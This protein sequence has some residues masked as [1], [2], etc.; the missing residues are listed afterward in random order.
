[1]SRLLR[2][3]AIPVLLLAGSLNTGCS[4]SAGSDP[5]TSTSSATPTSPALSASSGVAPVAATVK[6][7]GPLNVLMLSVDCLRADMPWNGY[8]RPIAPNLTRLAEESTVYTNAYSASSYTAQ[9]VAAIL[10]GR[11]ASTLYRSGV[12]FTSYPKANLFFPEVL[13]EKGIRSMG[14]FSHLYFGRGKGIEQGFDVW[15]LVP[16]ITFN[17]QTDEHVTSDKMLELGLKILRKSREYEGAFLRMGAFRRSA[18]PVHQTQGGAGLRQ[19]DSRQV[20]LR[21]LV[22]R[23]SHR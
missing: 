22:H 10:S 12:F 13:S 5:V 9:S 11:F 15:E 2:F 7:Q 20:R 16:G 18:R 4:K 21:G 8:E 14:W 6:S 19:Q 3:V 17:P 23:L 1:M